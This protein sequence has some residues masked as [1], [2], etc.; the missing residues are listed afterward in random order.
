MS[1]ASQAMFHVIT[2]AQDTPLLFQN[3]SV[4]LMLFIL[5]RVYPSSALTARHQC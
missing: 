5:L 4:L 1:Q 2:H 3:T